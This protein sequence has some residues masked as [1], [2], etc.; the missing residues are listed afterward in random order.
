MEARRRGDTEAALDAL[1]AKH[2]SGLGRL[3][4]ARA[5]DELALRASFDLDLLVPE[6]IKQRIQPGTIPDCERCDDICCAGLENLVSLRLSDI[7]S[8][9][10]L[11]RTDLIQRKKPRFPESLLAARP[12]LQELTHSELWRTL[13]VLRQIGE[14]HICAALSTEL[15]CTL[16][17]RWPLSCERFPYTLKAARREVVWGLRCPSQTSSS[18]N[19]ERS[20]EMFEATVDAYN[21][22]VRDAVLLKHA[23]RDLDEL[24]VGQFLI[25]P[26]EDPFEDAA[27][28]LGRLPVMP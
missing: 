25:G 11:E 26:K 5:L 16:H 23:R 19:V 8:L 6:R 4:S 1:W 17:P 28:Q 27:P 21:G 14:S 13:P 10:D 9:I 2:H 7:A 24:G 3:F 12:H 22:R 15:R 18:E 20:Q